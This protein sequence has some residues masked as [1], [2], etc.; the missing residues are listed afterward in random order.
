MRRTKNRWG[1]LTPANREANLAHPLVGIGFSFLRPVDGDF[2][3][4]NQGGA[5]VAQN[6]AGAVL[7]TA[8]GTATNN[9]RVRKKTAPSAPYTLVACLTPLMEPPAATE[10]PL[11]GLCWRDNSGGK[12]T[13]II[14]YANGDETGLLRFALNKYDSATAYN[15]SYT[16]T[17]G[18]MYALQ[19]AF[20]MGLWIKLEDDN[21]DRKFYLSPNGLDWVLY[22][23]VGRT[24]FHTPDE[25]GFLAEAGSATT[26][27]KVWLHSWEEG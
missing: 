20:G 11:A 6:T 18:D 19:L 24:D 15:S 10:Y 17:G 9:L 12:I 3:W 5:S 26:D 21:T 2:A 25:I 27:T 4:V 23:S 7:L 13:A 16:P 1:W 14:V 8:P 22:H